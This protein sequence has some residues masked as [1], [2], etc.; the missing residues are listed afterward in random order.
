PPH[1]LSK[2]PIGISTMLDAR[3]FPR[4]LRKEW[5]TTISDLN[6]PGAPGHCF[7]TWDNTDLNRILP[8]A[9]PVRAHCGKGGI[10]LNDSI[11][12]RA[13]PDLLRRDLNGLVQRLG[14]AQLL[15]D[16]QRLLLLFRISHCALRPRQPVPG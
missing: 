15:E 6:S 14:A 11:R 2:L 5:D 4:T 12:L 9:H 3:S 8:V 10:P 1:L 13:R 16:C 7:G